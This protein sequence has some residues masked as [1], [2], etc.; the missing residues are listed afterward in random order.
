MRRISTPSLREPSASLLRWYS[1]TSDLLGKIQ[2]SR[3][4][5]KPHRAPFTVLQYENQAQVFGKWGT[6]GLVGRHRFSDVTGKLKL[7]QEYF[8]P[9]SGWEWE[10]DWF[11]DPEKA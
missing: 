5:G 7:K 8:I 11:I 2:H 9:P 3:R 1:F 10:S 6:T 4:H